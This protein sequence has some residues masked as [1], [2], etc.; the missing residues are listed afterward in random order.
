MFIRVKAI[1]I[2]FSVLVSLTALGQ[3][4][5]AI[6]LP[7]H[8]YAAAGEQSDTLGWPTFT[9][10]TSVLYQS[11]NGGYVF[12][13]NGFNDLSK[14]M[15]FTQVEG[16][17]I[18]EVLMLFGAKTFTSGDPNSHIRVVVHSRDS[19]GFGITGLHIGAPGTELGSFTVNVSDID[20]S[21]S[22]TSVDISSVTI[23]STEFAVSVDLT[24]LAAGDTVG[25]ISTTDGDGG[26]FEKS[27]ELQSNGI[28]VTMLEQNIG[29]DLDC[30][31]AIFCVQTVDV[32]ISNLDNRKL[33]AWPNPAQDQLKI[34]NPFSTELNISLVSIDGKSLLQDRILGSS[35]LD[36]NVS[37]LVPGPYILRSNSDLSQTSQ[38]II[39]H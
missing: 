4:R 25:L 39:I 24:N 11:P 30:V 36:L 14:A 34:T 31:P 26:G 2:V 35:T 17:S 22:F 16:A 37:D 3:L 13:T 38:M 9:Q 6:P 21:G 7:T 10:G 8:N 29:W 28:W 15:T 20:T 23:D 1:S 27:W 5:E 32:G 12:G 33:A 19:L 18:D